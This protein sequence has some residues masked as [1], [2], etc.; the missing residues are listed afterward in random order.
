M[1]TGN[2]YTM[3]LESFLYLC[4]F[5]LV[6]ML[7]MSVVEVIHDGVKKRR[8]WR[9][10]DA[11]SSASTPW[12]T[13]NETTNNAESVPEL[14]SLARALTEMNFYDEILRVRTSEAPPDGHH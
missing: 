12:P 3:A 6:C 11:V 10:Q 2:P 8:K 7:Y 1:I 9:E 14:T 5:V 13:M 4:I